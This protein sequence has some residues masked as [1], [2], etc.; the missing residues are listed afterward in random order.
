EAEKE[1]G[2][3]FD[4][5][6]FHDALLAQG[7]VPLPVLDQQIRQFIADRKAAASRSA[8]PADQAVH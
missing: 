4:I 1:L 7:S 5:R 8:T 2:S 6:A 3:D